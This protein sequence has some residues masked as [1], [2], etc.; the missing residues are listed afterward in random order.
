MDVSELSKAFFK[1]IDEQ[2]GAFDRPIRF[3]P[4]PFDAGGSLNFLT[5]GSRLKSPV[6]YVSWDLF[7]HAAQKRG[8]LG[9]Y[10]LVMTCDDPD[11]AT[12]IVTKIGRQ[13]LQEV[14]DPGDTL[15]IGPWVEPNGA[16]QGIIFEQAFQTRIGDEPCGLL[17][18][19]G[20]TRPELKFA[21]EKGVSP[22]LEVLKRKGI[23]PNTLIGRKTVEL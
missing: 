11:W 15:D 2:V 3:H 1:A 23:Y 18:C 10:E 22:L 14:F 6:T 17:R 21:S 12:N 20:V 5:V 13:S 19:L 4:F 7:G 16:I 9:R 8:A